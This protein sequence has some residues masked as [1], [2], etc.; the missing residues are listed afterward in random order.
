MVNL[1]NR[2]L[3]PLGHL[4]AACFQEVYRAATSSSS[5]FLLNPDPGVAPRSGFIAR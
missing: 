5:G 4:S 2:R 1:A 3:Q